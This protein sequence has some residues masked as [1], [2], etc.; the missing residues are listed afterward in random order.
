MET[1]G[2]VEELD[3]REVFA[4][5]FLQSEPRREGGRNGSLS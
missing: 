2:L 5:F 3:R 1:S 4:I